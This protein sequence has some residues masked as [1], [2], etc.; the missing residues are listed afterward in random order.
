M[1][2]LLTNLV[3]L[4]FAAAGS[5]WLSGFDSR[6]TREYDWEDLIRRCVRCGITLIL[7]E[8]A[9][10]G[11]WRY[12]R[13]DDRPS[14]FLYVATVLP[15]ALIWAGCIS[16]A[17]AHVFHWLIDPPDKREYDPKKGLRE[18]DAVGDLI[19]SGRKA[20]A[21][22][23]CQALKQTTDFNLSA[24]ELTLEHLG[25]P[26]ERVGNPRPLLEAHRLRLEEKYSEAEAVLQSLLQENPSNSEAAF[27]LMRLYAENLKREDKAME[28]LRS[29]EQQPH[30][31]PA[32]IE[33]ARRSLHEWRSPRPQA[34]APEPV[35]ETIDELLA[36]RYFGTAIDR[37]EQQV[38]GDPNNFDAW[39][40][41]AEAHGRHCANFPLAQKIVRRMEKNPAFS[42]E[43]LEQAQNKL[44][45]WMRSAG[46]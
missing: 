31:S 9:F 20:E 46:V 45:E 18:L 34:A 19:R 30:I 5:W 39:L 37:L 15:L 38:Q 13:Y 33:F 11:L 40:K 41:L 4:A 2:Y 42:A 8:M 23:L 27:M 14:G 21:I 26:Q 17:L 10:Y 36:Q 22:K 29:L 25:V 7:V 44:T 12:W 28:I 3:V 16:E 1:L 24:L 6:L 32:Y 43:Q 35:P